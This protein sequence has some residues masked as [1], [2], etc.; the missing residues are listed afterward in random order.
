VLV[1][2]F[3]LLLQVANAVT[4]YVR[5]PGDPKKWLANITCISKQASVRA[6]AASG[7]V[8]VVVGVVGG[9]VGGRVGGGERR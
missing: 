2:L 5:R 6:G 1:V 7:A 9:G 8:V 3:M 4:A